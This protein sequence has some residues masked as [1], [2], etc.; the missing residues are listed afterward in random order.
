MRKSA[1]WLDSFVEYG[2]LGEA[3]DQMLFWTGV[4]TIAGALGRKCYF[5]QTIFRWYPNMFVVL[6][7]PPGIISKTT[8]AG[9][10]MK[11]LRQVDGV[12][13]GPN[14]VTW[15]ALVG[16]FKKAHAVTEAAP[17]NFEDSHSLNIFSGEFGNLLTPNDREMMDMLVTL[18]DCASI[19]KETKKDGT[20]KVEN[21]YLNL[22][23]CTTP[24]W[25]SGNIPTYMIEGGLVSRIIFVYADEKRQ[26][27]PYPGLVMNQDYDKARKQELALVDD[28][29]DISKMSG[30]FA[31]ADDAVEFGKDWYTK[32]YEA[33]GKGKDDNRLGG[34]I[35]RKQTHIH[36]LAM[37]LSAARGSSMVI[38]LE[39]LTRADK[40]VTALEASMPQIFDRI[41]KSETST[42]TDR[43]LDF[44]RQQPMGVSVARAYG[45]VHN[46]F[47]KV[48]DFNAVL[49]GLKQ[50]GMVKSVMVDG[51]AHLSCK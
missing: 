45:H 2:R 11:L 6:V 38:T 1:N 44:I 4:S 9:I 12:F 27:I 32:H 24:G 43:L 47:P 20:E 31:M 49:K 51:I 18:W 3:P 29:R 25:I 40:E 8:C 35:A 5:D 50:A 13:F 17:G 39:D 42:Q 36:K 23:A 33:H 7:A 48:D 28:L 30:E 10:G 46:F 16:A 14:V 21:T 22:I 26:Y 15:Q 19:H 37:I 34:Y 41:G